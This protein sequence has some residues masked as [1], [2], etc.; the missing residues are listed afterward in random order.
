[1]FLTLIGL[2]NLN[3]LL[4]ITLNCNLYC[5]MLMSAIQ[6][7]IDLKMY[8]IALEKNSIEYIKMK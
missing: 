1:M 5:F 7:K 3:L 8:K 4:H 2:F 6:R